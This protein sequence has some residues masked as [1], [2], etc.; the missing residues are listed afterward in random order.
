LLLHI[1]GILCALAVTAFAALEPGRARAA[2]VF[3][4]A[5]A[6]AAAAIGAGRVPDPVWAASFAA[7]GAGLALWKPRWSLGAVACGGVTAAIWASVLQAQGLTAP[8]A[9]ALVVSLAV[10]CNLL[11]ARRPGFA[12]PPLREE[13]LVLVTVL[14]VMLA[15][16]PAIG[17]GWNA[18]MELRPVPLAR[19]AVDSAFWAWGLAAGAALIG[20]L[21]SMWRRR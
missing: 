5:L 8:P 14:A 20:G 11:A 17:E 10:T 12:P 3:A 6:A 21:Y 19:P 4:A 15:A 16:A 2:L 13:A 9:Y 7:A 1:L 18:A